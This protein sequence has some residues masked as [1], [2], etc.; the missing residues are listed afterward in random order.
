M[1]NDEGGQ[2]HKAYQRQYADKIK[3]EKRNTS[4]HFVRSSTTHLLERTEKTEQNKH[5]KPAATA[6][7]QTISIESNVE[8]IFFDSDTMNWNHLYGARRWIH[9][10]YAQITQRCVG[11]NV[12]RGRHSSTSSTLFLASYTI[13]CHVISTL[14]ILN[15]IQPLLRH[16]RHRLYH[17]HCNCNYGS[18]HSSSLR[19]LVR[20][21]REQWL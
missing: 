7:T 10:I 16:H 3:I 15:F 8:R 18:M 19:H 4:V 9:K 1:R 2:M 14:W 6:A 5:Q 13:E 17:V 21:N 20:T 12:S 11:V